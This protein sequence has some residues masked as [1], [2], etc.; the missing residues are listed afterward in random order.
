MATRKTGRAKRPAAAKAGRGRDLT[1]RREP[2]QYRG[3]RRI[4]ELLDAAEAVIA[5]VGID[6]MTTNAVAERAGAGMGSL[7]HFFASKEAIVSALAERYIREMGPLTAYGDRPELNQMSLP[8]LANA[9]IDPLVD[10]MQRKPAYLPVF[11]AITQPLAPNPGCVALHEAIVRNVSAI[12]SARVPNTPLAHLQTR[13][14]VAVELVHSLISEA[15]EQP[16]PIRAAL[17]MEAKRVLVLYSEM[18]QKD[19][20]PLVRLRQR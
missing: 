20:D 16:E 2:K 18:L 11:H 13:A 1:V 4:E 15:F 14:I 9:I 17:I 5:E 3:Q 10:Y 19:D 6:A 12:I 8:D 7:Y